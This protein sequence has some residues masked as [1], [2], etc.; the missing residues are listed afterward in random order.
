MVKDIFTNLQLSA[1]VLA[2]SFLASGDRLLSSV[3]NLC[4]IRTDRTSVV[5]WIQTVSHSDSVPERFF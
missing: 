2:N 4:Q 1:P 5:N 3:V